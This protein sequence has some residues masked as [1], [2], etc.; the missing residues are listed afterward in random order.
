MNTLAAVTDKGSILTEEGHIQFE[1]AKRM[2]QRRL[3]AAERC[4]PYEHRPWDRGNNPWA[5]SA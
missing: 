2:Y 1:Q 4:Q 5:V 3:D